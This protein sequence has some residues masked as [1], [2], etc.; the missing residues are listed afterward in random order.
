M[1][2]YHVWE[3][4]RSAPT[5]SPAIVTSTP[6]AWPMLRPRETPTMIPAVAT[7]T[8]SARALAVM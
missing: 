7:M 2:A 4:T 6:R 1:L 3:W 8:S 5:Q